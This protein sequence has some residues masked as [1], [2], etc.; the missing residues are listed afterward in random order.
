MVEYR[1]HTSKPKIQHCLFVYMSLQSVK[2]ND[3]MCLKALVIH[4]M[5]MRIRIKYFFFLNVSKDEPN[6]A[7]FNIDF[8]IVFQMKIDSFKPR[9]IGWKICVC[10][11]HACYCQQNRCMKFCRTKN[12]HMFYLPRFFILSTF[13]SCTT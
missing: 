4:F 2:L 10:M 12:N 11:C 7:K 3:K 6:V 9:K 5:K 13:D 8:L 1:I